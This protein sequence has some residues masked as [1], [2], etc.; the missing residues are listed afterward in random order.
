MLENHHSLTPE[1]A[2]L[3]YDTLCRTLGSGGVYLINI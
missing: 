1:T 2:S 3:K